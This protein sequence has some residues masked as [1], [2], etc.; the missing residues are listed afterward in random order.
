[1]R[2]VEN[3]KV[4]IITP[5]HD[6]DCELMEKAYLS[7][8]NQT[9]GFENIE[10]IV[11]FHNSHQADI[12]KFKEIID[13]EENIKIFSLENQISSPASPRNYAL[14]QTTGTYIGFL[15]ADDAYE[16]SVCEKAIQELKVTGAQIVSFRY[17]LEGTENVRFRVTNAT[18]IEDAE[19]SI[20]VSTSDWDSRKYV[21]GM[22]LGITTKFYQT[23]FIKKN[24]LKFNENVPFASDTL[25]NLECFD[26]M[27]N[28]CY[29]PK[30]KGYHYCLKS[31]SVIQKV[32]KPETIMS[33]AKGIQVI[34]DRGLQTKLEISDLMW[35][36]IA[37]I[38]T[39]IMFSPDMSCENVCEIAKLLEKYLQYMKPLQVSNAHPKETIEHTMQLVTVFL[40]YPKSFYENTKKK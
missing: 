12:N 3:K 24:D 30:F 5:C 39:T 1:M 16:T 4:S 40:K 11:V 36:L 10:W 23:E 20:V 7:L 22:G 2:M 19:E 28:I 13:S 9:I 34:F 25:F 35:E 27:D 17:E 37:Y 33:Y 18:N 14:S 6:M 38:A 8:K 31:N 15:D 26:K 29:L 32:M 21:Y